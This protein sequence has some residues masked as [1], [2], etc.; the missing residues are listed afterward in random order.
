MDMKRQWNV[1]QILL[2]IINNQ[3]VSNGSNG[4]D[5]S[6]EIDGNCLHAVLYFLLKI[7]RPSCDC[8]ELLISKCELLKLIIKMSSRF[9]NF[10]SISFMEL[11]QLIISFRGSIWSFISHHFSRAFSHTVPSIEWEV[12]LFGFM[13]GVSSF[14]IFPDRIK[15]YITK[16]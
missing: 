14:R 12:H 15:F 9:N 2:K 11:F 7:E 5:E 3:S 16:W 1:P 4:N 8:V 13:I 6:D 10:G